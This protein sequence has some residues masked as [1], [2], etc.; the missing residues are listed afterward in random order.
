MSSILSFLFFI[1][2]LKV[3]T[4]LVIGRAS[5]KVCLFYCPQKGIRFQLFS[6]KQDIDKLDI[7]IAALAQLK[8]VSQFGRHNPF[9]DGVNGKIK[10]PK[11]VQDFSPPGW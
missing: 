8:E 11:K 7:L 10:L 3:K 1:K 5:G 2:Y 9:V 6:Q 4:N